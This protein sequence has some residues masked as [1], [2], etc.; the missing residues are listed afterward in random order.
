M[1]KVEDAVNILEEYCAEN[2][3]IWSIC[4]MAYDVT[5]ADVA[6]SSANVIFG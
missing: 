6:I 1:V 2:P 5:V 4:L 3:L